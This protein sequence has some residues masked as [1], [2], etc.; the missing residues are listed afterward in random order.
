MW[1][2]RADA[3]LSLATIRRGVGELSSSAILGR[4]RGTSELV[5]LAERAAVAPEQLRLLVGLDPFR[6]RL[7]VERLA[8][9][10]DRGDDRIAVVAARPVG[11]ER[12]HEALV[13][14]EEVDGEA[15]QVRPGRVAGAEVVHADVHTELLHARELHGGRMAGPQQRRLGPARATANQDRETRSRRGSRPPLT[16]ARAPTLGGPRGSPRSSPAS[17][18][19]G[20]TRSPLPTSGLP[21]HPHADRHDQAGLLGKRDEDTDGA[22]DRRVSGGSTAGGP[23]CRRQYRRLEVV[24]RL[25][26]HDE[27]VALDRK[28]RSSDSSSNRWVTSSISAS[29]KY[30][31]RAFPS[32]LALY[33]AASALRS[34]RRS[35]RSELRGISKRATVTMPM[36][37]DRTAVFFVA[38]LDRALR[39]CRGSSPR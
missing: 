24:D 11:I 8:D 10:R 19:V 31:Q 23:R 4:G 22:I 3:A 35:G 37:T 16:R 25:V 5:T 12:A 21:E 15:L 36:L 9:V 18:V 20:A 6:D 30:C 34:S 32:T 2:L 26:V 27:L 28:K 38:E 39:P 7:E 1:S 17:R 33:I 14:L 29:S 13:D